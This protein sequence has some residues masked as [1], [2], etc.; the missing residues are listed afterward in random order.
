MSN[1]IFKLQEKHRKV[2][3]YNNEL[4]IFSSKNHKS[5]DSLIESTIKSK[6][7]ESVELLKMETLVELISNEKANSFTIKYDKNGKIKKDS[8]ILYDISQ[9]DSIMSGIAEIKNFKKNTEEESKIKPLLINLLAIVTILF[10]A[11]VLRGMAIDAESGVAY[12]A[13]GRNRGMKQ[14]MNYAVENL[15]ADGISIIAILGVLYMFYVI[16]K[17]YN[18]PASNVIYK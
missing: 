2:F 12:V 11:F 17:R 13:R 8:V 18:N 7:F 1:K 3:G 10:V 6:I 5:Y 9:R 15:G 14:L 4:I 16:H